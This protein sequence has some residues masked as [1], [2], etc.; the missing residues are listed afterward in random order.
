MSFLAA[1]HD[2]RRW[3]CPHAVDIERKGVR[4][5]LAF[6]AGPHF[7]LGAPLARL[8]M[9]IAM[10]RVLARMMDIRLD[11][12]VPL[13]RQGKMIVRGVENLPILFTAAEVG[14]AELGMTVDHA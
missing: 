9:R 7:C 12:D 14:V 5:H 2:E 13:R 10:E 4:N 3:G 11:P 1:N 6:G 8:E